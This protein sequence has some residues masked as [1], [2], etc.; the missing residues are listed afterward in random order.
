[1]NLVRLFLLVICSGLIAQS[2]TAQSPVAKGEDFPK[3]VES[4]SAEISRASDD[5]DKKTATQLF[6]D[7]DGYARKKFEAFEKL[8]MPYDSQLKQKIEKEQRDLAAKY[9][10]VLA[11]R[12]PTG[13]DLYYLGMLHNLAGQPDGWSF[14]ATGSVAESATRATRRLDGEA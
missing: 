6:D 2:V 5:L 11:G 1:M 8:K 10:G 13:N 7:A 12:K 3:R 14:Q 4:S 9:A